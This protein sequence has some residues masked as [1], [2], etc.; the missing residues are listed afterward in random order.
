MKSPKKEFAQASQGYINRTHLVLDTA[1]ELITTKPLNNFQPL[2][3]RRQLHLTT[4]IMSSTTFVGNK[5]V[6]EVPSQA[7]QKLS[8]EELTKQ[9]AQRLKEG[10]SEAGANKRAGAASLNP[11]G[12]IFLSLCSLRSRI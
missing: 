3:S 2:F 6:D 11:S 4:I 10:A 1:I 8:D 5:P 7:T 12:N 9:E